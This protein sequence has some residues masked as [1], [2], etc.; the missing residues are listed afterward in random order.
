MTSYMLFIWLTL[1]E[2]LLCVKF[3]AKSFQMYYLSNSHIYP[4]RH[5]YSTH[6]TD[7]QTKADR[8]AGTL[9]LSTWE[10]VEFKTL[11]DPPATVHI[12]M[13]VALP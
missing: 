8:E 1:I 7:E 12:H 4:V 10:M 6:F 11:P 3:Y 5:C 13:S 9:L 2:Y